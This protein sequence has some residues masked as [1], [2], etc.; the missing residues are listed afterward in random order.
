[1]PKW[2]TTIALK[3]LKWVLANEKPIIKKVEA[4]IV[5][6]V[7]TEI[8]TFKVNDPQY[9]LAIKSIAMKPEFQFM[10]YSLRDSIIDVLSKTDTNNTNKL[11][12][13]NGQLKMLELIKNYLEKKMNEEVKA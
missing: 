8:E 3:I 4:V 12:E 2:V 11:I 5:D 6:K 13:L 7:F 10:M 9:I 1:M